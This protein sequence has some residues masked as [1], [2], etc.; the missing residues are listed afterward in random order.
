MTYLMNNAFYDY[1]SVF[2]QAWADRRQTPLLSSYET[3]RRWIHRQRVFSVLAVCHHSNGK[4]QWHQ[5]SF[6]RNSATAVLRRDASGGWLSLVFHLH[7]GEMITEYYVCCYVTLITTP[8]YTRR[9]VF[10]FRVES[11]SSSSSLSSFW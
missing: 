10:C 11:S 4:F 9:S 6:R 5:S 2:K 1:E 8:R 7:A 3:L